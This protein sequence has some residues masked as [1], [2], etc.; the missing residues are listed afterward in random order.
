MK[1]AATKNKFGAV[2]NITE[3]EWKAE[4][5]NSPADL[6]VVV[7]LYKQGIIHSRLLDK[8]METLAAKFK[9]TKFVRI[10][11]NEAIHNY[12]DKNIPTILIYNKGDVAGQVVTLASFGGD[13]TTV[14]D[15]EW[16]LAVHGAVETELEE[17]PRITRA[18]KN[19]MTFNTKNPAGG[20]VGKGEK[21]DSDDENS[22]SDDD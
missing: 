12:P 3:P 14:E 16:F 1:A 5:T 10:K 13:A 2:I 9:A 19:K 6:F 11:A 20:F 4:V 8:F 21:R 7:N 22:D 15:I 18:G 17:D